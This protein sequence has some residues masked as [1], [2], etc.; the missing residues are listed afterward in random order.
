[1]AVTNGTAWRISDEYKGAAYACGFIFFRDTLRR[2]VPEQLTRIGKAT[3]PAQNV[4]GN[5]VWKNLASEGCNEDN[6]FGHFNYEFQRAFEPVT[7]WGICPFLYKRCD[8]DDGGDPCDS[9][10]PAGDANLPQ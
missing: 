9:Q 10:Y 3:F 7:P 4:S 5:L 1:V 2:I 6:E 8:P